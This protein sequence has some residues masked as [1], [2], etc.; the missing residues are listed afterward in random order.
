MTN[1]SR[2]LA[3]AVACLLIVAPHGAAQ[4]QA[5]DED[6]KKILNHRLT[7]EQVRKVVAVNR[8]VLALLEKDADFRK[9]AEAAQDADGI[10]ES[11][12]AIEKVPQMTVLLKKHGITARDYLLAQMAMM[13]TSMT[14]E[15]ISKGQMPALPPGFPTHNVDFWKANYKDLQPLEAEWKKTMAELQKLRQSR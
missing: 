12:A 1:R 14:H 6:T 5:Q 8:E 2:I 15:F 10:E 11:I 7:V 3:F 13:S 4:A 9:R